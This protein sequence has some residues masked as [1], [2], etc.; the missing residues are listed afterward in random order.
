MSPSEFFEGLNADDKVIVSKWREKRSSILRDR[1]QKEVEAELE[2]DTSMTRKSTPFIRLLVQTQDVASQEE[3]P[4]KAVKCEEAL[5]TIWQPTEEQIGVLK[6]GAVLQLQNVA[7]RESKYDGLVQLT[8]NSRTCLEALESSVVPTRRSSQ[9]SKRWFQNLFRIHIHSHKL[10]GSANENNRLVDVDTVVVLLKVETL[11]SSADAKSILY[12]TDETK[13][14]L[15]I[16]CDTVP[17]DLKGSLWEHQCGKIGAMRILSFS[18]LR[19]LP[20]DLVENCA[21]ARFCD[22]SILSKA[23]SNR[24]D[25]LRN[26]TESSGG[27]DTVDNVSYFMDA[28]LSIRERHDYIVALGYIVGFKVESSASLQ[29]EVDTGGDELQDWEFPIHLLQELDFEG[30]EATV[31]LCPDEEKRA[32]A[33]GVMEKLF[34]ARGVLFR[35]QLRRKSETEGSGNRFIVSA[36]EVA[37]NMRLAPILA[38]AQEAIKHPFLDRPTAEMR[39]RCQQPRFHKPIRPLNLHL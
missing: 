3:K 21:V 31:S 34:R 17:C 25:I 6:A 10:Q 14:I 24:S 2:C 27:Q 35:F 11:D 30:S 5:L 18:N 9:S 12:V 20:F 26:W 28:R 19:V 36:L 8:A 29:I 37:E 13:L 22:T 15:R 16:H 7:V 23:A 4:S 39:N 32:T 1:L 33:L 38:T